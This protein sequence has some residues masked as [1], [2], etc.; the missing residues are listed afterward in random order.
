MAGALALALSLLTLGAAQLTP[1][2]LLAGCGD[3]CALAGTGA[4]ADASLFVTPP[5]PTVDAAGKAAF[6][7]TW[8]SSLPPPATSLLSQTPGYTVSGAVLAVV[9]AHGAASTLTLGALQTV[10]AAGATVTSWPATAGAVVLSAVWE[11]ATVPIIDLF[12]L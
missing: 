6:S 10:S 11:A 9:A 1:S 7:V 12:S 5:S 2:D 4:A 3:P 8:G